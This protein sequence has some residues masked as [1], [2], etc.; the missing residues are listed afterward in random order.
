MYGVS[1]P[2]ALV[3]IF[4][5]FNLSHAESPDKFLLY[6]NNGMK[7]TVQHPS[8]WVAEEDEKS[9]HETVWFNTADRDAPIFSIQ[10]RELEQY[11][12]TETMTE[13][14]VVTSICTTATKYAFFT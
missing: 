5:L 11:L 10:I 7:F 6:T 3:F 9:P 1:I 8:N 2:I 12:D 4:L 13:K 14:Y